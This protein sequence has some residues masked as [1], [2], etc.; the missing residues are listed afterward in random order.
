MTAHI[1]E[2]ANQLISYFDMADSFPNDSDGDALRRVLSD[3]SNL[4]KPMFI[5]FQVAA[6]DEASAV[7]IAAAARKLGYHVSVHCSREGG[8]P[9]TCEC[10]T[11]MLATYDGVIAIQADLPTSVGSLMVFR[12]AGELLAMVLAVSLIVSPQKT[13]NEPP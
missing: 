12:M 6:P 8:L 5:D 9:W 10:S 13:E 3:G 2:P 11:R 7:A 1:G 4:A